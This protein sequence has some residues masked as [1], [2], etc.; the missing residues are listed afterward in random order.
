MKTKIFRLLKKK[1]ISKEAG[2][3]A[4]I[5][6]VTNCVRL[7]APKIIILRRSRKL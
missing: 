7:I 1:I 3:L 6:S 5:N 2:M 4:D